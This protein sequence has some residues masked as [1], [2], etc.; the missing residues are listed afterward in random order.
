MASNL[1]SAH[2]TEVAASTW[3]VDSMR[4]YVAKKRYGSAWAE[5]VNT[6]TEDHITENLKAEVQRRIK[7]K[8]PPPSSPHGCVLPA[9]S[10]APAPSPLATAGDDDAVDAEMTAES[11]APAPGMDREEDALRDARVLATRQAEALEAQAARI[12]H[13]EAMMA[14]HTMASEPSAAVG[15]GVEE[16][17]SGPAPT[18]MSAVIPGITSGTARTTGTAGM[19]ASF[20]AKRVRV[21]AAT[22]TKLWILPAGQ[23][24]P[25]QVLTY[26]FQTGVQKYVNAPAA[27]RKLSVDAGV[28][29]EA[30]FA[31]MHVPHIPLAVGPQGGMLRSLRP[32]V[33]TDVPA[34][35]ELSDQQVLA[36]IAPIADAQVAAWT[37]RAESSLRMKLLAA[38]IEPTEVKVVPGVQKFSMLASSKY[39]AYVN[40]SWK[41]A[42]T[43]SALIAAL[44]A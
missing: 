20:A 28:P 32:L 26:D 24:T 30:S 25:A 36:S 14:A 19:G 9:A 23:K 37:A 43:R 40:G 10:P 29:C 21:V 33:P 16:I 13:L 38:G 41:F 2:V 34:I 7:A 8:M 17:S 27:L 3:T 31:K 11:P 4:R 44:A 6:L 1:T 39:G 35:E 15:G 18:Y 5:W 22:A 42:T 12:R